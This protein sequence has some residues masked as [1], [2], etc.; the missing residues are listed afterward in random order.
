MIPVINVGLLLVSLAGFGFTG[1]LVDQIEAFFTE[2][3]REEVEQEENL[4]RKE[5]ETVQKKA[6]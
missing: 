4:E 2:N 3:R 1:V 5:T 6:S